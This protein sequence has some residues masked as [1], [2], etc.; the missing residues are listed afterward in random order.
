MSDG[1]RHHRQRHFFFLLSTLFFLTF[2]CGETIVGLQKSCK[3]LRTP[4]ALPWPDW[5]TTSFPPNTCLLVPPNTVEMSTLGRRENNPSRL[6]ACV[7]IL[8]PRPPGGGAW[9]L[10]SDPG[11]PTAHA[12]CGS[13]I[14]PR[15]SGA[16]P[17]PRPPHGRPADDADIGAGVHPPAVG[18][19]GAPRPVPMRLRPG[20]RRGRSAD[21]PLFPQGRGLQ[22]AG[23]L[24]R[25]SAGL[26]A[27]HLHRPVLQQGLR[28]DGVS[29]R[30]PPS[31][32]L[33]SSSTFLL[34]GSWRRFPTPEPT[35]TPQGVWQFG[36]IPRPPSWG[37]VRAQPRGTAPTC[38]TSHTSWS[39][40]VL[41]T[42]RL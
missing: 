41:L 36:L 28:Q 4:R 16:A 15:V 29:R 6:R 30:G 3:A 14:F 7:P 5:F 1:P 17:S 8:L 10:G 12:P 25:G 19:V 11:P 42:T 22:Q 37:W 26:R 21:R 32:R 38:D 18:A 34:S 33:P 23:Q 2:F 13:L 20:S 40:P 31:V 27:R 9:S 35:A 24:R 39:A